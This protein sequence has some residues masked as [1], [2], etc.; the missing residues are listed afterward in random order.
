MIREIPVRGREKQYEEKVDDSCSCRSAQ[1]DDG[2]I[3]LCRNMGESGG[4]MEVENTGA[5]VSNTTR[6]IGGLD[7]TFGS[8]GAW[9]QPQVRLMTDGTERHM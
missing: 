5:M 1:C 6:N 9:I 7:Y 2:I 4:K 8:S 3:R